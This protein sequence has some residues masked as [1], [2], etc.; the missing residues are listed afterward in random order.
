MATPTYV[1]NNEKENDPRNP[2]SF[3]VKDRK[4]IYNVNIPT[5]DLSLNPRPEEEGGMGIED[6]WD[7]R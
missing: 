2:N 1:F 7:T 3:K 4:K 5:R 6:W